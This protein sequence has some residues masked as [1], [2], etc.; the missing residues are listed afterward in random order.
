MSPSVQALW[1]FHNISPSMDP[2][3]VTRGKVVISD[4]VMRHSV[5]DPLL[6]QILHHLTAMLSKPGK[7]G[8]TGADVM[9]MAGEEG[10]V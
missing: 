3:G 5:F 7:L 9:I 4:E 6:D 1:S 8:R 10:C 2:P